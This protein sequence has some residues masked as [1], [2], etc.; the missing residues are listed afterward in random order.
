MPPSANQV[1]TPSFVLNHERVRYGFAVL[2]GLAVAAMSP[3]QER[4][5]RE[6]EAQR[7]SEFLCEFH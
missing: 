7:E 6:E 1:R 2:A 3:N 4:G 5:E